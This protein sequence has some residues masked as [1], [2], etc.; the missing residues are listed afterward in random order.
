MSKIVDEVL[1]ENREFA[2]SFGERAGIPKPPKRHIAIL[3]CMD[4]RMDPAKFAGLCDGDAHILRNAGGRASDDAI[5]SLV[6]SSE[7]MDT[8]EWFVI[9]HTDCGLRSI[10]NESMR[11][12]LAER[13]EPA[14]ADSIDWLPIQDDHQSVRDDVERL[15]SHPLV[16]PA[17]SIYG[18]LYDVRT[19][20]LHKVEGAERPGNLAAGQ[21]A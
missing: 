1:A 18:Y 16:S 19:G 10:T 4:A 14:A 20:L 2:K 6:I 13:A 5:R 3:T 12:L 7:L 11:A 21:G 8:R 15:A 9:H 17:I